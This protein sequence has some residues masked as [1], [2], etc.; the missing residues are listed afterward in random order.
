MPKKKT[1]VKKV[2]PI[3][4]TDARTPMVFNIPVEVER[5]SKVKAKDVFVNYPSQK[6]KTKT[7]KSSKGKKNK[8]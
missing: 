1:K 4:N 2:K 6:K 3:Q 8:K 5:D 7:D